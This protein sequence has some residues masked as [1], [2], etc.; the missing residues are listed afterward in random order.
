MTPIGFQFSL[1][2]S[3]M[4]Y[5]TNT[6]CWGLLSIL[7]MRF[8]AVLSFSLFT[9][10]ILSILFMRF[11]RNKPYIESL[12]VM[13]SILF[14]RFCFLQ[15]F[16]QHPH[17]RLSILFMR[18]RRAVWRWDWYCSEL[19]ILFMRFGPNGRPGALKRTY[20]FNSL[21]EILSRGDTQCWH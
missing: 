6:S 19:S 17:I 2:D 10:L 16:F 7:F 21:Y 9:P 11:L 14:M 15:H 1:W 5:K 13:L 12:A 4:E 20:S 8:N 3:S 18:F